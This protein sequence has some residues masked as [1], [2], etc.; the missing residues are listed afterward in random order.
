M[1]NI[2]NRII[3]LRSIDKLSYRIRRGSLLSE[4]IV[5]ATILAVAVGVVGKASFKFRKLWN[6]TRHFQLASDEL[7]NQMRRLRLLDR[8]S[9]QSQIQSLEIDET[10]A[11]IL[12]EAQLQGRV[13]DDELGVRIVLT[14][15]WQ[16]IGEPKPVELI[17]WLADPSAKT[18]GPSTGE[19]NTSSLNPIVEV[20]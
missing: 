16:R 4:V 17:G 15:N 11:A 1:G 8:E 5:A 3:A 20:R 14:I 19:E 18:V 9:A 2:R 12:P 7:G 6:D 10:V 13:V